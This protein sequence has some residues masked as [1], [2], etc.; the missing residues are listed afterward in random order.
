MDQRGRIRGVEVYR[1]HEEVA[2]NIDT[3]DG[4]ALT[5]YLT[6]GEASDVALALLAF[7]KDIRRRSFTAS[8]LSAVVVGRPL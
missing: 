4:K 3:L 1:F 6:P 2:A 7:A 8:E 5:I